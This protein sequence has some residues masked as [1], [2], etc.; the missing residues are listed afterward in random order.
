MAV[1]LSAGLLNALNAESSACGSPPLNYTN[2]S[3]CRFSCSVAYSAN[4]F[5]DTTGMATCQNAQWVPEAPAHA[6]RLDAG[7]LGAAGGGGLVLIVAVLAIVIVC[8]R[9]RRGSRSQTY[10]GFNQRNDPFAR[11][12]SP[13]PRGEALLQNTDD[14]FARMP[15]R[16]DGSGG[17]GGDGAHRNNRP[18]ARST[19]SATNRP[20]AR[21]TGSSTSD[22]L[23]T[24][25]A[26]ADHR[27][28]HKNSNAAVDRWRES[29]AAAA[30]TA[31]AAAAVPSSRTNKHKDDSALFDPSD[32]SE[33]G[34]ESRSRSSKRR[35]KKEDKKK[36]SKKHDRQSGS[37][38]GSYDAPSSSLG[39]INTYGVHCP[40]H[41]IRFLPAAA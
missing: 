26:I 9:R 2:G 1:C 20:A 33:E 13:S 31:A 18:A 12:P 16:N 19:G 38:A 6:C 32:D 3:N 22:G 17:G 34:E 28:K 24:S 30:T 41:R 10:T 23:L 25:Q 7:F 21:S 39:G 27:G 36:R 29:D 4:G 5:M 8:A 37:E 35:H 14:P 15:R 11:P 40:V